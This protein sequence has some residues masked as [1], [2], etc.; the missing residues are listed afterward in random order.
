[1]V[2]E[3]N[4]CRHDEQ[5]RILYKNIKNLTVQKVWT[6]SV[7]PATDSVQQVKQVNHT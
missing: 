5:K 2:D 7:I 6:G 1:M 4:K 3:P